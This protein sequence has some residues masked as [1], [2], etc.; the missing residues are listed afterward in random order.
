MHIDLLCHVPHL[1]YLCIQLL[2]LILPVT[3]HTLAVQPE[4]YRCT[5]KVMLHIVMQY[6]CTCKVMHVTHID[7]AVPKEVV[8]FP[9]W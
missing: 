6:C 9:V 8:T 7:N 1:A 3:V 4:Q 2:S 5:C